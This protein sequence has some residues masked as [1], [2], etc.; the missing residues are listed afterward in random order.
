MNI[1]E[2]FIRSELLKVGIGINS[3]YDLVNTKNSYRKAIPVLIGLLRNEF[4]E[5][6]TCEGIVRAL[7]VKEAK[8]LANTVLL[9]L[10]RKTPVVESSLRWAIGNAFSVIIT[11]EDLN[12]VLEIVKNKENGTSRQ[13]FVF[14][15]GKLKSC[16]VENILIDLLADEEVALQ[17]LSSIGKLKVWKAM[18]HVKGLTNHTNSTIRNQAKKLLARNPTM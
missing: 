3:I 9:D 13:M 5:I 2:S 8:G 16:E 14:A 17:A 4:D 10:Y 11:E 18:P 12:D 6:K 15:L 1:N 7:T